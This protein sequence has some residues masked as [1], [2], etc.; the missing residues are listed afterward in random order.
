MVVLVKLQV[1]QRYEISNE[2]RWDGIMYMEAAN[3]LTCT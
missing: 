1:A 3:D 2:I